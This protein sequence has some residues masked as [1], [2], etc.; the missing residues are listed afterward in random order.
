MLKVK[1]LVATLALLVWGTPAQAEPTTPITY[2]AGTTATRFTGLAF[3][4]CTAPTLAQLSAWK[5]SPYKALGIYIGGANRSCAQP[6]LTPS[7]VT[8]ATAMG[9]RL[10]PVFLGLQAPCSTRPT[11][12]KM[13]TTSPTREGVGGRTTRSPRPRHWAS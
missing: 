12:L 8:A 6:Q 3:D 7:W 2:N 5:A 11:A 13:S 10:V 1:V 4:T 9:W